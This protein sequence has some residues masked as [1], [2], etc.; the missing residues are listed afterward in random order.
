M[1][2]ELFPKNTNQYSQYLPSLFIIRIPSIYLHSL[3]GKQSLRLNPSSFLEKY[4]HCISKFEC[5]YILCILYHESYPSDLIIIL[6][7]MAESS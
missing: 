7:Y 5:Y 4:E 2:F 6:P 1:F 3:L